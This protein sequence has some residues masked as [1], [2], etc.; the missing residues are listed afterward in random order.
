M[1]RILTL[2]TASLMASSVLATPVL[3]QGNSGGSMGGNSMSGSM[4]NGGASDAAPGQTKRLDGDTSATGSAPGQLKGDDQSATEF[5]PGQT[6]QDAADADIDTGDDTAGADA[7]TDLDATAGADIDTGED[8]AEADAGIDTTTT[9]STGQDNF[10]TVISS[11]R[12]GKSDL[13]GVTADTDVNVVSVDELME[14]NNRSALDNALEDNQEQIDQLR[15]DLG[16]IEGLEGLTDT[17]I[18]SA[19]AARVDADGSLTVYTDE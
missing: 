17:Q 5:A 16:D 18:D 15:A 12:A 1:K 19:V 7:E 6:N 2:V 10:G 3:A 9:A 14:G 4:G 13:S 8:A 11:I